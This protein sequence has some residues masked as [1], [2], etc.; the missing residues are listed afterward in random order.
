MR[1]DRGRGNGPKGPA[2][3]PMV[4][5]SHDSRD[6]DLAAAFARLLK[7]ASAGMVKSFR[8]SDKGGNEGIDYGDEW[9]GTL[10]TRLAAASDVVCVLTERSLERPWILYEAGVAKGKRETPVHGLMLGVKNVSTGPFCQF[11]NCGD[12]EAALV[13]L[14]RQ[15]CRRVNGLEPDKALLTREVG[16]FK[17]TVTRV[18]GRNVRASGNTIWRR[19][20]PLTQRVPEKAL[21]EIKKNL[22]V[23]ADEAR[24]LLEERGKDVRPENVR[25]NLMLPDFQFTDKSQFP[26][27]LHFLA[28]RP[29]GSYSKVELGNR[30][31]PGEGVSGKVFLDG[32]AFAEDGRVG[33]SAKKLKVMHRHLAAVAGFPLLDNDVQYAFGVVCV[34]FIGVSDIDDSDLSCLLGY[35]PVLQSIRKIAT[36]LNPRDNESFELAFV[37]RL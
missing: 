14:V 8:S 24:R 28:T 34:D 2:S 3:S 35:D 6:A 11:Q 31:A 23:V 16:A 37:A 13:K 27:Q 22:D 21:G 19:A 1:R 15:L 7:V 5:I 20:I 17:K 9:Y 30:F 4:F 12:S 32:I 10:M 33:V 25:V 36:L 29:D 18:L 26:G